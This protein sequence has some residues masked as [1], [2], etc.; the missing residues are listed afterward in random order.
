VSGSSLGGAVGGIGSTFDWS[1][2]AVEG[3]TVVI[4]GVGQYTELGDF[5][6]V[7]TVTFDESGLCSRFEMRNTERG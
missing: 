6:N 7:W 1:I 2:T 3:M 4:T 5:D